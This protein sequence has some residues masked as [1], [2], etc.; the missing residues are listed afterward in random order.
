MS[1]GITFAEMFRC[2][3]D[4]ASRIETVQRALVADGD[5]KLPNPG[6]MHKQLVFERMAV[7]FDLIADDAMIQE[8]LV[9][10]RKRKQEAQ[11]IEKEASEKEVS[12]Q[13]GPD[14]SSVRKAA[15]GVRA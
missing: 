8:R 11:R 5:L 12:E 4:E 10:L 3:I 7:V 14:H 9:E 15:G 1:T 2:C 13:P 6:Q